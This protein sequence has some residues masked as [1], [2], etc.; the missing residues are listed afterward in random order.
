MKKVK[1]IK[2]MD[3]LEKEL[4]NKKISTE[5]IKRQKEI[6]TRLLELEKAQRNQEEDNKRQSNAAI[7]IPRKLPPNLEEYLQKRKAALELY[8][9]V[10]PNLKPFYQNLVEKY[11]RLAN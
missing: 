9:T 10:P 6:E 5:S 2:K 1:E 11:L 3:D 4:A 8:K 7:E